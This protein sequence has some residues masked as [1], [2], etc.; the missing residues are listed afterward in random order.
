MHMIFVNRIYTMDVLCNYTLNIYHVSEGR[1]SS[2]H[3]N[4]KLY[5]LRAVNRLGSLTSPFCPIDVS[6]SARPVNQS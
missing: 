2:I 6:T 4:K 1:F 3:T 5:G